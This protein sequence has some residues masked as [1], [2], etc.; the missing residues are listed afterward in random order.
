MDDKKRFNKIVKDIKDVKIQGAR[1]IAKKALQAYKLI[2]TKSSKRKLLDARPTEPMME[3]VLDMAE[4]TH[5]YKKILNHFDE[6]QDK[7]NKHVLKLIKN[8]DVV[9]T[10]CHS[11]NVINALIYAKKKGHR[12]VYTQRAQDPK[13]RSKGAK[14]F[15][16]YNTET[17]PLFQGRKTARELRKAGIK[18]T[19][20]VD[21]AVGVALSGEQGNKKPDI[22]F[23]GADAL[24]KNGVVNKI[25]SETIAK[26]AKQENIPVY[27]VADSWKF[28]NKKVLMEGRKLDEV[29]HRAP[30]GIKLKNPAFE[31]DDG[32]YISGII[33]EES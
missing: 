27:I 2:P 32:K 30:K 22:V 5:D 18:V 15:E 17:R 4:E 33:T 14:N 23:L 26:L 6:A 10:H 29:W 9:F 13:L 8:N 3:N 31:F 25:G 16:V 11:T 7:I 19:M 20:F 1:N 28:T 12:S 24:L 21:S